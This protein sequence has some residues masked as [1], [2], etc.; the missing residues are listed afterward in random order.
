MRKLLIAFLPLLFI[1]SCAEEPYLNF[2]DGHQSSLAV[3]PE[4]TLE[5][6]QFSTNS[7]WKAL[8]SEDWL[9][10]SPSS[11]GEGNHS[12]VLHI[13]ENP[14]YDERK[15]TV[16][17]YAEGM[18]QAITVIQNQKEGYIVEEKS[19]RI[20]SG[21]GVINV[22]VDA[23][24]DYSVSVDPNCASWLSVIQVKGLNR[25]VLKLSAEKNTGYDERACRVTLSAGGSSTV[26]SV[27]QSQKDELIVGKTEYEIGNKGGEIKIPVSTNIRYKCVVLGY[28]DWITVK[29]TQTKGLEDYFLVLSIAPNGEYVDRV[30]Q[31]MVIG[32][33]KESI[34]TVGQS[35]RD[36]M[37]VNTT[38]F[39]IGSDG[40]EIK[41][42]VRANVNY[43]CEVL[44]G[45][46]GW[47]NVTKAQTKGLE[48]YFMVLSVAKNTGYD[49]R[50]GQVR[51]FGAG[52]E[53]VVTVS[54][55][56]LDEMLVG[57]TE[58]E[59][60]SA[61][62]EI[63]VPVRTNIDYDCVVL[64]SGSDW[65]Q[66]YRL[67][68]KGLDDYFLVLSVSGNK[69][70]E[71]RVGQI[72]VSGAGK[73]SFVT[74]TQSQKDVLNVAETSYMIGHEEGEFAV[75]VGHNVGYSPSVSVSWISQVVT[76][77]YEEDVLMFKVSSNEGTE[78]REG[79]IS[80]ISDDG[81]IMKT[82][83]VCQDYAKV[84]V[85]QTE[86]MLDSDSHNL[87][88]EIR[89]NVEFDVENPD[90]G[91]LEQVGIK[92]LESDVLRY[93]IEANSTYD[94]RSAEIRIV[95]SKTREVHKIKVVQ[96]QLDYL[97][98]SL[99]TYQTGCEGGI[100]TVTVQSNVDYDVEVPSWIRK[101]VTRALS[102]DELTFSID[103]NHS[104]KSREGLIRF[105]SPDR[106]LVHV[107][108]VIQDAMDYSNVDGFINSEEGVV[109]LQEATIGNGTD[110]FIMG[111]GFAATQENFG[112][113]GKYDRVMR[114]AYDNYF[115]IEPFKS[116]KPYFNVYYIKAVS[117]DDHDAVP[118]PSNGASQGS[119]DTVFDTE[120]SYGSTRIT[121][122]DDRA[123]DY[124]K[125]ALRA[126]GGPRGTPMTDEN[127]IY[128]R[129][130]SGVSLVMINV[131]C[132][133]GTCWIY[134]E[135][136]TDYCKAPSVAYT[137]LDSIYGVLRF[138][139]IH[140]AGGH[141]FGKLDDEYGSAKFS[142]F[143]TSTWYQLDW[144]HSHGMWRNVNEYYSYNSRWTFS[145]GWPYTTEDSVYWSD[146]LDD[147]LS[148]VKDEGLGMYEGASTYG[149][150]FCR[151]T[152]NSIMNSYFYNDGC[153]FNAISRWAIWYRVMRLTGMTTAARFKDSLAEFLAFDRNLNIERTVS[154]ACAP[155]VSY[156]NARPLNPP[157]R[158]KGEW[159]DG[160]F[161][162]KDNNIKR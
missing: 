55:S 139:T 18:S 156:E 114:Q 148:Y 117:K 19:F 34:I 54:Q 81:K 27:I 115:S 96:A 97:D 90:V 47:I 144:D 17:I 83:T 126:K 82:V 86:F 78:S 35:Q 7:A 45:G 57:T 162:V 116:L 142:S 93:K 49:S 100:V 14:D 60:G 112:E 20:G 76:K 9:S 105:V 120:F 92:S 143:N 160:K 21:G 40:G 43:E 111:D 25:C 62:G 56:Q 124:A 72:K 68:T 11:G 103:R 10:I 91:W 44:S 79:E 30:G 132:Y 4:E 53:S 102:T 127:K 118:H 69:D 109:L 137:S 63:K 15:A 16:T 159:I 99:D 95:N 125:Q 161:V 22:P 136:S 98:V 23:N 122:D 84:E 94:S 29:A 101:V 36:D 145:G 152:K 110:L 28:A 150:L 8:S 80:F 157:V 121:G 24:V 31:L 85:P 33:D 51:I 38:E 26:V 153:Y 6:I 108:T 129:V 46:A 67:Q 3:S 146:L 151:P 133:A 128:N 158:I 147:D 107:L 65:L 135:S 70:Y 13:A 61:G 130:W 155:G 48:D 64:D 73:E 58:F 113:D 66:V 50:Q 74:V 89:T 140:E 2:T 149:E 138:V 87:E 75:H 5:S 106:K 119:A 1:L 88:I 134:S 123:F 32:T 41:V 52:K 131:D 154:T 42:P 104:E 37:I 12:V 59:I 141:G 77:A 39:E 71:S